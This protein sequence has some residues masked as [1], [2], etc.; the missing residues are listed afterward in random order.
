MAI[1]NNK[2]FDLL[3]HIG[4]PKAGSSWLEDNIFSKSAGFFIPF[5]IN[6][7]SVAPLFVR[8]CNGRILSPFDD[9]KKEI[10]SKLNELLKISEGKYVISDESLSGVVGGGGFNSKDI[11]WRLN[12]VFSEAKILIVVRKQTDMIVSTYSQYIYAGGRKSLKKY[13]RENYYREPSF[14]LHFFRYLELIDE[15]QR[16]FGLKNVLILPYELLC[17]EPSIFFNRLSDFVDLDVNSLHHSCYVNKT[18]GYLF[19]SVFKLLFG[20]FVNHYN[21]N[22]KGFATIFSKNLIRVRKV[23]YNVSIPFFDSRIK[24]RQLRIVEKELGC[25]FEESNKKLSELIGIDLSQYGY[26]K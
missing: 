19:K 2:D 5:E 3:I 9:N 10:D 26:H 4:L 6:E 12:R 17:L 24:R 7:R 22:E 25:K 15:Y 14:N 11:A 23:L 20:G 21:V 16:L 1:I 13:L 8:D 18:K